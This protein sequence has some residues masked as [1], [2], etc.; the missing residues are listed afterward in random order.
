MY[1]RRC[2]A[3]DA[4]SGEPR[5]RA[6]NSWQGFRCANFA[7]ANILILKHSNR[8]GVT[9]GHRRLPRPLPR[10]DEQ[11]TA[12]LPRAKGFAPSRL[13]PLNSGLRGIRHAF[14]HHGV[15]HLNVKFIAGPPKGLH[16]ER[17]IAILRDKHH[18]RFTSA[19]RHILHREPPSRLLPQLPNLHKCDIK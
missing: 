16:S 11:R 5:R 7:Q 14:L 6:K 13:L 1:T 10:V 12:R 4:A 15:I 9:R 17:C 19:H 2:W 3:H 8:H 18:G